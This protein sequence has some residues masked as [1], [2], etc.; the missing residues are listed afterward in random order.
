MCVTSNLPGR[1]VPDSNRWKLEDAAT[2]DHPI[3]IPTRQWF[4][5]TET[6]RGVGE[7][8]QWARQTVGARIIGTTL[9]YF[10]HAQDEVP[11]IKGSEGSEFNLAMWD[12]LNQHYDA[13]RDAGMGHYIMFYS[14]DGE[15]PNNYGITAKSKA[16]LR[17]FRYA[18]ARLGCYPIVMWD[19]GIDISETR[20]SSWIDWFADWFNANDPWGH[21]VGSRS[22]GG[23]G[24]KHPANGTYFSDGASTLPDHDQFVKTWGNS[25]VP[26]A[27]TDRWRE[28]GSRGGFDRNKIRRGVWE[29][30]LTGGSAVYV[31]G[32]NNGGY[33]DADYADDFKA[34]PDCGHAAEFFRERVS[35]P[36]ALMPQP[37]LVVSGNGIVLAAAAGQE[38]VAYYPAGGTAELDLT[39]VEGD[40]SLSWYDPLTG[41]YRSQ[42][43]LAGGAVTPIPAPDGSD[44]VLHL[45][46]APGGGTDPATPPAP[47]RLRIISSN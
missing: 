3:M 26:I 44:W 43:T 36:G 10:G 27:F 22:G 31:T 41:E 9:V 45:I 7:F 24:G 4:K 39:H 37:E 32:N 35:N 1:L 19:T 13:I 21:P 30:G 38:Y 2:F 11:Y 23:S 33:L 40:L 42:E 25:N 20:S 34:A 28:D 16:E 47:T 17:L 8:I 5:R 18:V 6:S 15:S 14:D 29:M 46:K 12:R